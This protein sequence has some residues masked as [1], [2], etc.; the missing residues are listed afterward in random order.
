MK[1]GEGRLR[2]LLQITLIIF[3]E[4]HKIVYLP[5]AH[6][7][8]IFPFSKLILFPLRTSISF[9][10]CRFKLNFYILFL[11]ESMGGGFRICVQ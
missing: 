5:F 2:S 1:A 7:V 10:K 9:L 11:S 4:D 8:K 6:N 3:H